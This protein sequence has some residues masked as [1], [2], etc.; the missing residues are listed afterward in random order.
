MQ[1]KIQFINDHETNVD[2]LLSLLKVQNYELFPALF[3]SDFLIKYQ[4][5]KADLVLVSLTLANLEKESLAKLITLC[6]QD[7]VPFIAVLNVK[8]IDQV[9]NFFHLGVTDYILNPFSEEDVLTKINNHIQLTLLVKDLDS[10]VTKKIKEKNDDEARIY[11]LKEDKKILYRY[12][13]DDIAD[14]IINEGHKDKMIASVQDATVM[15]IEIKNFQ[16]I[17]ELL[18]PM[19][20]AGLLNSVYPD[21][22]ELILSSHGS[23]NNIV[24]D[25]ILTT[26]GI[27]IKTEKDVFNA[28]Q[29]ALSMRDWVK[30][31]K[32]VKPDYVKDI[33]IDICI[34]I[35]T[36]EIFAG[37]IGTF[38]RLEYTVIG[39]IVNSSA[40]LKRVAAKTNSDIIIDEAT[41]QKG[42]NFF[43][44]N[45]IK[46]KLHQED[47]KPFYVYSVTGVNE[48]TVEKNKIEMFI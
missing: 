24:N 22:M 29:C 35:T 1:Y 34:G 30:L 47:D 44:C 5:K 6:H 3:S 38:R 36:G 12:F 7:K 2:K 21:F 15:H 9:G 11:M 19:H 14:K 39:N 10:Q 48:K 33:D 26:Y 41:Y 8:N 16:R 37:S 28:I 27:P 20:L 46:A 25:G 13:S 17:S 4:Q 40:R 43:K 42:K 31:F 18:T 23:I 32:T 45:K